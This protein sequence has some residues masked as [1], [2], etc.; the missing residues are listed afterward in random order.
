MLALFLNCLPILILIGALL[1][2]KQ[3]TV[4]SRRVMAGLSFATAGE[5]FY[6]FEDR[7]LIPSFSCFAIAYLLYSAAF[8]LKRDN[9][10]LGGI[11]FLVMLSVYY[12]A[13]PG[14]H[15]L[16]QAVSYAYTVPLVLMIWRAVAWC[17]RNHRNSLLG[18]FGTIILA[19][20]DTVLS[21][22]LFSFPVPHHAYLVSSSY[23]AGQLFIALSVT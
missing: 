7:Y 12:F 19:M 2:T 16:P 4:F 5:L 23:Y 22:R 17:R 10:Y 3:K 15:G 6:L 1:V 11:M 20:S 9:L 14:V 13:S 21:D 8:G 18:L